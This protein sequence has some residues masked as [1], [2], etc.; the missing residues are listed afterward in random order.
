MKQLLLFPADENQ[1]PTTQDAASA[2]KPIF[3]IWKLSVDGASR[4]N[5]GPSGAGVHI[6]RDDLVAQTYGVFLGKKTNNEAEYLALLLGLFE[7]KK[8]LQHGDLVVIISDS[9]LLVRQINGLY[10]VKEPR[11]QQLHALA[12]KLLSDMHYNVSHVLRE[13]NT[14]ADAL[15]NKGIDTKTSAP[16]PFIQFLHHHA[17][18]L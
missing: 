11:L 7:L 17:V 8:L 3:S 15:A 2:P 18:S 9:Q 10:K 5:P 16:A 6:V 12:K 13:D 1:E 14:A 4:N